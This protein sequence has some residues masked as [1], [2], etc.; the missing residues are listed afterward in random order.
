MLRSLINA[1]PRA[2]FLRRP[3]GGILFYIPDKD[4]GINGAAD[5]KKDI[6]AFDILLAASGKGG[7]SDRRLCGMVQKIM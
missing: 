6:E 1:P 7:K 5:M 2:V 4:A 3:D